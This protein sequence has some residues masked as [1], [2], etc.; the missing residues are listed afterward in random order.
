[1]NLIPYEAT[2]ERFTRTKYELFRV[3]QPIIHEGKEVSSHFILD[4]DEQ[5]LYCTIFG[6]GH[7]GVGEPQLA[8]DKRLLVQQRRKMAKAQK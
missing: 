7:R 1:M 2:D 6:F 8:F 5:W 4:E 3:N